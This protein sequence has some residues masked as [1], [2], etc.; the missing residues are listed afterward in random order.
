[1]LLAWVAISAVGA[2]YVALTRADTSTR[3]TKAEITDP[4]GRV[5]RFTRPISQEDLDDERFMAG[6][7]L[8]DAEVSMPPAGTAVHLRL[9]HRVGT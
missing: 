2:E 1:L 9:P 4:D 5:T 7:Y 6:G 3:T 8:E